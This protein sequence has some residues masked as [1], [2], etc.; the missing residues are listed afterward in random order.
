MKKKISIGLLIS[1]VLVGGI[2]AF[3]SNVQMMAQI[4]YLNTIETTTFTVEGNQLF[5]NGEINSKTP[6]QLKEVVEANPN[7]TT[8][9]M[10]DV[11]GS[12][13]DE[14]NLPMAT[15]VRNQGLNT[16]LTKTSHVASGGTDFFLAGVNRTMEEGAQIGVHSW[17]DG[18]KEAK[19]VPKNDPAHEMNRK[20]IE[21]MLGKDDF[22]WYTIYA[23]PASD[24]HYMTAEEIHT[25]QLVTQ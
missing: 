8:I 1:L 4:M 21:D 22:Y 12:C 18:M 10:L 16:Y 25:F 24:I 19:D 23:A 13:D 3:N 7:I 17:S 20:Y 5:M 2:F 15:W 14:A 6:Q 9:V 11:P